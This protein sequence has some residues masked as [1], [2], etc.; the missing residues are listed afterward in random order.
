MDAPMH[1][2]CWSNE[3][4]YLNPRPHPCTYRAY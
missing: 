3:H 2:C 1:Q 4:K